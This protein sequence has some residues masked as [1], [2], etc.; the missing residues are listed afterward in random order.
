MS[1]SSDQLKEA[2]IA[3]CRQSLL[4]NTDFINPEYSDSCHC[5]ENLNYVIDQVIMDFFSI[6]K[7]RSV[8]LRNDARGVPECGHIWECSNLKEVCEVVEGE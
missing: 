7:W 5:K 8:I 3:D 2:I 4:L 6:K 1:G